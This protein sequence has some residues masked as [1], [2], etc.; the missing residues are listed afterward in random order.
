[1]EF[2]PTTRWAF[3]DNIV[4]IGTLKI[5]LTYSRGDGVINTRKGTK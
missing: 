5:N 2:A 1:M 4:L 3:F